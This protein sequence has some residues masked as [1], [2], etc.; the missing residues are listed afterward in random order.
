M[1]LPAAFAILFLLSPSCPAEA[2]DQTSGGRPAAVGPVAS[3]FAAY[4]A[5]PEGAGRYMCEDPSA[6]PDSAKWWMLDEVCRMPDQS[7]VCASFAPL[8][9]RRPFILAYSHRLQRW[10]T[11]PGRVRGVDVTFDRNRIPIIHAVSLASV[12]VIV[13]DMNPLAYSVSY[14]PVKSAAIE[15][16]DNLESLLGLLGAALGQRVRGANAFLGGHFEAPAGTAGSPL[17]Q[18][19]AAIHSRIAAMRQAASSLQHTLDAISRAGDRIVRCTQA[20]ELGA[21]TCAPE[22]GDGA[23]G[24]GATLLSARFDAMV[25]ARGDLADASLPCAATF[26]AYA[27][28]VDM[29]ARAPREFAAHK[30]AFDSVATTGCPGPADSLRTFL[31]DD[32]EGIAR[33]LLP[34]GVAPGGTESGLQPALDRAITTRGIL[35]DLDMSGE[36]GPLHD[37]DGL[38]TGRTQAIRTA[39]EVDAAAARQRRFTLPNGSVLRWIS[40]LP[41]DARIHWDTIDSYPIT[42]AADPAFRSALALARSESLST[43]FG[44]GAASARALG[45]AV[46]LIGTSIVDPSW[47]AVPDPV[48]PGTKIIA[49]TGSDSR[50]GT[51]GL[52]ADYRFLDPLFPIA[53]RLWVKPFAQAGAGLTGTA[54]VFVGVGVECFKYLRLSG[55][56]TWQQVNTLDGQNEGTSVSSRDDIR[57]AKKF[58]GA[59]YVAVSVSVSVGSLF[60]RM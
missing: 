49:R 56:W 51:V 20:A 57:T 39:H 34:G 8:A 14:G 45:V 42:L 2:G 50:S 5:T 59:G 21:A 9:A 40:I 11:D 13:D 33:R 46:G 4:C 58:V 3:V 15:S 1:R 32:L 24:A 17:G 43:T 30:F 35:R 16:L 19:A 47:S 25:R 41:S 18:Y 6:Y 12:L 31:I 27:D 52:F 10:R 44:V 28:A 23:T 55:G 60:T 36:N 7:A 29:A 26:R 22:P 48:R 37:I 54:E 38:L 53:R